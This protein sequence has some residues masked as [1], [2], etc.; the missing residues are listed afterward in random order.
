M[1]FHDVRFPLDIALN[2]R[3]GPQRRT[4]VTTLANGREERNTLWA[5]SRRRYN[6]GSGVKSRRD[7]QRLIAFFEE[8]RGRFHGFRWHDAMDHASGEPMPTPFDQALGTGDGTRTGFQ[9]IKRYGLTFAPYDRPITK[10]RL[11]TVRIAVNG[12]EITTGWAIEAL[13]GV[14]TF[15]EAPA[16]G[17]T[18]SAGFLFDVPVRFDIDQLEVEL[19]QF[20]AADIPDIPLLEIL[21]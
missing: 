17:A 3:G 9:L 12:D 7:M 10:P 20:D 6:A 15:S 4:E 16:D 19:S 2:A 13:T 11:E 18:I 5:H 21:E 8:R 1:A 14:I